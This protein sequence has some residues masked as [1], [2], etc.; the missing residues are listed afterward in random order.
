MIRG[1]ARLVAQGFMVQSWGD[2]LRIFES[3]FAETRS[4]HYV[5]ISRRDEGTEFEGTLQ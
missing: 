3:V 2:T 5:E 4:H 1:K